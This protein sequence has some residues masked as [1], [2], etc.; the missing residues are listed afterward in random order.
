MK[1][2][3][4]TLSKPSGRTLN[5]TD[6][7]VLLVL[8]LVYSLVAFVNL[9]T[10]NFPTVPWKGAYGETAIIDL[11]DDRHVSEIWFNGNIAEGTVQIYDDNEDYTE[12]EQDYGD[13]FKWKIASV[14]LDTTYVRLFVSDGTVSFNEIALFDA[15][16]ERIPATV[17]V[18]ENDDGIDLFPHQQ[19]LLDEQG[20]VPDHPSYFNG[21][22]FDEIYHARTA[23]EVVTD[24]DLYFEGRSVGV[25][26]FSYVQ[27]NGFSIYEWTHP[28]LGKVLI[29][30]G[31]RL[32]GMNPFGW[33]FTGTL[34]GVLILWV[35]Y[36][37]AKRI[38]CRTD[39]A[40]L[41]A[42]LFA[43]DC[44]HYS[45][46]RIAT[47]DVYALFFTLLMFLC[48]LDYLWINRTDALFGKKLVPLSLCGLAFGLG[49]SSKWTCFYSGAG[50]AVLFFG[51][52]A[53]RC[54]DLVRERK[55]AKQSGKP[56]MRIAINPVPALPVLYAIGA[57]LLFAIAKLGHAESG[58][59]YR[60]KYNFEWYDLVL[61]NGFWIPMLVL[62]I[63]GIASA[64]VYARLTKGKALDQRFNE[65]L[66]TLVLCCVFFIVI[67]VV[68][69]YAC[70]YSFYLSENRNTLYEQVKCLWDKQL[71]MYRYHA[72]LDATHP[73]QSMWYE[74]PLAEKSVWFYAGYPDGKLSNI[75]STGNPAVWYVSAFGAVLMAVEWCFQR[76]YRKNKGFWVIFVGILAG[77]LPWALVTRCVF[78]YHYFST[79]PFVVLAAV[80]LLYYAEEKD[81]R[82]WSVKWIWLGTA[83]VFFVLMYPAISGLPC[84][85]A[86]AGFI[87]HVL[88]VFGKVYYVGV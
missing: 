67:P 69:Y 40:L 34:F 2:F 3:L 24:T 73:C 1:P 29:A 72:G 76:D 7:A 19:A 20:T 70:S 28:Q 32:F 8:L 62:S 14:S 68:L 63:A 42:G 22:Y 9:G 47:I 85:W 74:W 83:L 56:S 58:L 35:L 84:S 21:M 54:I 30:A 81:P 5:R 66:M 61:S 78:L 88:T 38:F 65:Q 79:I 15:D 45:Q 36:V 51:S 80:A 33:R 50:L 53:L 10:T 41:A 55:T 87:E 44:M 17:Y 57:A 37:L 43:A 82:L 59:L 64:L 12:F 16:G 86:Y 23:Y 11:G 46:T 27:K 52:F 49:A 26:D 4:L 75:S 60:W 71:S 6:R 25:R 39:Y 18:Q 48:M 31:V 77:L 13:M